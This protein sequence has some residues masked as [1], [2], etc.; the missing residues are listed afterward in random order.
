MTS[1]AGTPEQAEELGRRIAAA[2]G[3]ILL[4]LGIDLADRQ[5]QTVVATRLNEAGL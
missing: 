3:R 5:V 1:P 4:D 2:V